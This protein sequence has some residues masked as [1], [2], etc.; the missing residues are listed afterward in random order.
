MESITPDRFRT[1]SNGTTDVSIAGPVPAG[2]AWEVVCIEYTN[3]DTVQH[4]P[5]LKLEISGTTE[6][7][8]RGPN[9]L[10]GIDACES[11]WCS[12]DRPYFLLEGDEL[13]GAQLAAGTACRW[14]V[15][16]VKGTL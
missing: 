14:V 13:K 16:V 10:G 1:A 4:T 5:I 15:H 8:K 12:R 2:E 7:I 3:L 11:E 9:L 6:A